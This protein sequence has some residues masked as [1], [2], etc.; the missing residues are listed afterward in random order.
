MSNFPN[1]SNPLKIRDLEVLILLTIGNPSKL[2]R[3]KAV[4]QE[5][6][7]VNVL[8]FIATYQLVVLYS[9]VQILIRPSTIEMYV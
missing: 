5:T 7:N 4:A 8:I 2:E 3:S 1:I 6:K 9:R